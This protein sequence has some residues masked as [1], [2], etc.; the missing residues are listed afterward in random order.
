MPESASRHLRVFLCHS[1]GDKPTVRELY[2]RLDAEGWI[3]AWLDEE[4]LYPGH[5]WNYEIELAVEAADVIIVCL[6]KNSVTKE[7]Y[8][9][10]EL[11]IVLDQADYKPEGTLFIIPVRLEECEPPQRLRRWQ[12]ADYFPQKDRDRAYQRLL[13]SLRNRAKSLG[14]LGEK[15]EPILEKPT[16]RKPRTESEPTQVTEK[17][18]QDPPEPPATKVNQQGQ[19]RIIAKV[20]RLSGS[21]SEVVKIDDSEIKV[22]F[23]YTNFASQILE[24]YYGLMDIGEHNISLRW[25]GKHA[26]GVNKKFF[27]HKDKTTTVT[28]QNK[29]HFFESYSTWE[30]SVDYER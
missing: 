11:K 21:G 8:V 22:P 23:S 20:A 16:T 28:L 13:V 24:V 30:I 5:D 9:Q 27:I 3:D 1:S 10:R 14:I 25:T 2:R 29:L 15:Q 19:I 12:Y 17:E 7:G 6:T 26:G 4:K 18:P